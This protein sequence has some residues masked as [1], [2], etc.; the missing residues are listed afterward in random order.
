MCVGGGGWGLGGRIGGMEDKPKER[1]IGVILF[2]AF[3]SALK[4]DL[5]QNGYCVLP[6]VLSNEDCE[7]YIAQYKSWL[8]SFP[9]TNPMRSRLSL[10]KDYAI[11]HCEAAWAV[12][13]AAKPVF[14][15]IW[16]TDKLLT[17]M[18]AV[19]IARPPSTEKDFDRGEPH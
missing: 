12:R 17:S 3:R 8:E 4:Q 11:G 19:A 1:E 2:A 16:D 6:S 10:V 7:K 14:S 5:K 15:A 13:L 18:D 9:D